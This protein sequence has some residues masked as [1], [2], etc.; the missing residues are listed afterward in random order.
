MAANALWRWGWRLGLM[1]FWISPAASEVRSRVGQFDDE[2]RSRAVPY[3]VY[4]DDRAAGRQP[5]LIASHGLGGSRDGLAYL[6]AF[7][8]ARGFVSIH[9]QHAGSDRDVRQG[10]RWNSPEGRRLTRSSLKDPQN[11]I[12][13][14]RDIPFVIDALER[15]DRGDGPLAG[16]LDLSRI[17]MFGHSYGAKSVL[18]AAGERLGPYGSYSFAEPRLKAAVALSPRRPN[19]RLPLKEVYADLRIPLFHITGTQDRSPFGGIEPATR[20]QPF[21]HI[22]A[23]NQYLLVLDQADHMT[24][25]GHRLDTALEKAKDAAHVALIR[26]AVLAFFQAH[27]LDDGAALRWLQEKFAEELGDKDSFAQH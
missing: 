11:A 24:F 27:L 4:F 7:L 13:R 26:R 16:R 18:V 21:R 3:R 17:G 14:F 23:E 1:I 19:S 6:G 9:L 15:A 20:Q 10:H 8:A 25:S 12:E 2:A 5:V 22:G